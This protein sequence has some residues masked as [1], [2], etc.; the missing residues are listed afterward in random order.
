MSVVYSGM[1]GTGAW[2]TSPWGGLATTVP[3]FG[4]VFAAGDRL[5]RVN[6][7]AA[8]Q[9]ISPNALGD[10]L[11]PAT[12]TVTVPS[13]GKVYTVLA[14]AQTGPTAFD[15][16]LLEELPTHFVDVELT[17]STLRNAAGIPVPTQLSATF[18]GVRLEATNT[19]ENRTV[20]KGNGARDIANPPTPNS[21]VGGALEINSGGDYMM[22]SGDALLR[23]LII[24]R[25]VSTPGDFFHLP[26][27][28]LGL[29]QK[30][31][32]PINDIRALKRAIV[33]E[34][35]KEPDII[36]C[37]ANVTLG[38]DTIFIGLRVKSR[39][40]GTSIEFGIPLRQNV[41]N[42]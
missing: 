4:A 32:L 42:Y 25:L 5:I 6:L 16:L 14:V 12:W 1:W 29:R 41:A 37:E 27:Y 15:L 13:T 38:A 22:D 34:I 9:T 7:D 36:G 26:N 28:G 31:P 30:E 18:R 19:V 8:A 17:T 21:P 24:R 11:N 3:T 23:K 40:S 39:A 10:A 2:G 33:N 20:R 35:T